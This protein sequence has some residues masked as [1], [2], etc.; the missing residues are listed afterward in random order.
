[1]NCGKESKH[2]IHPN[3]Y[4]ETQTC[5]TYLTSLFGWLNMSETDLLGLLYIVCFLLIYISKSS[6][7]YIQNISWGQLLLPPFYKEF[8][9][10]FE[11]NP[12]SLVR[13]A[14]PYT[15]WLLPTSPTSPLIQYNLAT[16]VFN[17]FFIIPDL[18]PSSFQTCFLHKP[19][20]FS[21]SLMCYFSIDAF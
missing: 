12:F 21:V 18:V 5:L 4:L 14:K 20:Q 1:M 7:F 9:F 19:F 17:C 11:W 13:P 16:L 10:S 15:F 6:W 3:V 8:P 2:G